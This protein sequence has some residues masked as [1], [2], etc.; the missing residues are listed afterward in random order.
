[1]PAEHAEPAVAKARA[2]G[3]AATCIIG[4]VVERRGP[5]LTLCA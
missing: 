4:E 3:A 1:L 2:Q 5:A